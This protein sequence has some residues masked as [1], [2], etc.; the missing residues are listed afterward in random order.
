[1]HIAVFPEMID[2]FSNN[3][4]LVELQLEVV[5]NRKYNQNITHGPSRVIIIRQYR[6]NDYRQ[7]QKQKRSQLE[8]H[9]NVKV[10]S[11]EITT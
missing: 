6:K 5:I 10:S 11:C 7:L 9:S 1:M 4:S 2:R 3:K 8:S